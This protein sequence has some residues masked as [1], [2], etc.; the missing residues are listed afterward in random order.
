MK[1]ADAIERP[2]SAA[3]AAAAAAEAASA[4]PSSS[5]SSSS[6]AAAAAGT[7]SPLGPGE[8]WLSGREYCARR[9]NEMVET[10]QGLMKKFDNLVDEVEELKESN[11]TQAKELVRYPEPRREE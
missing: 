2:P 1:G 11:M 5:S 7:D 8:E 9:E 10:V 3:A 4:A 6:A